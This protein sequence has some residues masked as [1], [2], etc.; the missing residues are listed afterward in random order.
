LEEKIVLARQE[1][2]A[3]DERFRAVLRQ[4]REHGGFSWT[5]LATLTGMSVEGVRYLTLDLNQRRIA[6]REKGET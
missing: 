1:R 2:D 3:A 4:A 6:R 5:R